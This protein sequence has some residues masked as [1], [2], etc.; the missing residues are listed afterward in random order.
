MASKLNPNER[1]NGAWVGGFWNWSLSYT[2][3]L[4]AVQVMENARFMNHI[5]CSRF[6]SLLRC[7][8]NEK[9][10]SEITLLGDYITMSVGQTD[11]R[12]D[13]KTYADAD[14]LSKDVCNK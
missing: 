8:P 14:I 4:P 12:T 13:L 2:A 6:K 3:Q 11:I 5:L 7:W 9:I 1:L 10:K